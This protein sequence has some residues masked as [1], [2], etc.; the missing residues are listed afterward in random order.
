[1]WRIVFFPRYERSPFDSPL[2]ISSNEKL[3]NG[4]PTDKSGTGA[5]DKGRIS[6]NKINSFI[7]RSFY[8]R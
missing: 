7:L 2:E 5:A 1:M 8:L 3:G 6:N 4:L